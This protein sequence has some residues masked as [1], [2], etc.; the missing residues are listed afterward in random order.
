MFLKICFVLHIRI[1]LE[2]STDSIRF[3]FQ[4]I[5]E[6]VTYHKYWLSGRYLFTS[7]TKKSVSNCALSGVANS[8][9]LSEVKD[10]PYLIFFIFNESEA[11]LQLNFLFQFSLPLIL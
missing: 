7:I 9:F 10:N 1:F 8:I 3:S 11:A 2:V 6:N 4:R 5:K